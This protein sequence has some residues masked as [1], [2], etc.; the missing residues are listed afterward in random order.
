MPERCVPF[1]KKL[2]F[3]IGAITAFLVSYVAGWLVF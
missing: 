3:A 1:H 2:W